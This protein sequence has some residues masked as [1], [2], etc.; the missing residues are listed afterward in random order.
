MGLLQSILGGNKD[1]NLDPDTFA[2]LIVVD[3]EAVL[4]DVRTKEEYI[5]TRIPKSILMDIYQPDFFDKIDKLDKSKNY[6]LYC[7]SGNRSGY[8]VTEMKKMGFDNVFHL[9]NGIIS[10]DGDV[11]NG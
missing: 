5:E 2:E 7:R 9:R 4:I 10:W 8:A 11:E 3:K 6:Y 1:F